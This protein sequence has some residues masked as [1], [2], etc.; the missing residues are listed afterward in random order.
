MGAE[1]L[2]VIAS[3]SLDISDRVIS[4]FVLAALH[5]ETLCKVSSGELTLNRPSFFQQNEAWD[6]LLGYAERIH[7]TLPLLSVISRNAWF[8]EV[9]PPIRA[10]IETAL[11][12]ERAIL[13]LLECELEAAL[14]VLQRAGLPCIVLKGMDLGPRYY[15]ECI[16]R[17]M[18]DVDLLVPSARF[19]EAL[20]LLAQ[21]GYAQVG[22]LPPGRVRVEL[23]RSPDLPTVELHRHLQEGDTEEQTAAI[24]SRSREMALGIEDQLA[25]LIRHSLVQH[26]LE[27][28]VWLN[29]LH[30]VIESPE[31]QQRASWKRLLTLIEARSSTCA[32]WFALSLLRS[33]VGTRIPQELITELRGRAGRLRTGL[34]EQRK[35]NL[36]AWFTVAHRS[37]GWVIS[38]RFLLRDNAWDAVSYAIRRSALYQRLS[39]RPGRSSPT[40]PQ[41]GPTARTAVGGTPVP[42]IDEPKSS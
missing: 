5:P 22:P 30:F 9:A 36:D 25:F 10:K 29:D 18:R 13:A 34:L 17:P 16:F 3:T 39:Q 38:S 8:A 32:A 14:S 42:S 41:D 40:R 4:D 12:R 35:K 26:L 6:A 2:A 28:P 31:F 15:P 1:A 27:S 33:R 37:P 7:A 23:G 21:N 24:W 20:S 19:E 11:R